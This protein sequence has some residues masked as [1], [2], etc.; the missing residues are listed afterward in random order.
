MEGG[1]RLD[2]R[3]DREGRLDRCLGSPR[4]GDQPRARGGEEVPARR[5]P[6][7]LRLT[8]MVEL[9]WKFLAQNVRHPERSEWVPAQSARHRMT[10]GVTCASFHD[11]TTAALRAGM[12]NR[13]SQRDRADAVHRQAQHDGHFFV[14]WRL[15][16]R[17]CV[18]PGATF[19]G[20]WRTSTGAVP[21]SLKPLSPGDLADR[22]PW[23][24]MHAERCMTTFP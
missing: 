18:P 8:T 16:E 24:M 22:F 11:T 14:V 20:R 12:L 15:V 10:V 9:L 21:T 13:R 17:T 7:V 23:A 2:A 6:G 1:R 19:L 4:H 3:P 5:G